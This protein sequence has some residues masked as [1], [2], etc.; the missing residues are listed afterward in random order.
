[1]CVSAVK[2]T[3][4]SPVTQ[5]ICRADKIDTSA[6]LVEV[7]GDYV[8]SVNKMIFDLK[9]RDG[10]GAQ[11]GRSSGSPPSFLTG[12]QAPV[13]MF[14]QKTI[15]AHTCLSAVARD[16]FLEV[17]EPPGTETPLAAPAKLPTSRVL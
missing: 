17:R 16:T 9:R 15:P 12:D 7:Y 13:P 3:R 10:S 1:M 8:W 4:V 14:G 2:S 6:L 5:C 11:P